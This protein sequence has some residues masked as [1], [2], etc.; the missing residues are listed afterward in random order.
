MRSLHKL[1]L[2]FCS[3]VQGCAP[4][5]AG[6]FEGGVKFFEEDE[7]KSQAKSLEEKTQDEKKFDWK[8]Q[9]DIENDQFF[10]EGDYI[11]PAPLLEALRRPTKENI[12]MFDK[13]NEAR[14]QL[15]ER[16]EAARAK[17]VGGEKARIPSTE[18]AK[19]PAN[20]KKFRF[21][22][23]FDAACPH[24][25]EMFETIN[26]L[27]QRGIYVEAIRVDR[28]D[29]EVRGLAI[30]WVAATPEELKKINLKAVPMTVAFD[31]KTKKAYQFTGKKSISEL[32]ALLSSP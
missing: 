16:Y 20:L 14:N 10:R 1:G 7:R 18:S 2:L 31:D 23:Y 3:L 17:Y 8:S 4:A 32:G 24:C 28:R 22:F 26:Q 12:V 6:V 13:W 21:A 9:M 27:A 19:A 11:P 25:H 5:F 15:L 29:Q 30:P